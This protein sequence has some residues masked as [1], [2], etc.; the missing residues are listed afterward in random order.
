METFK[1]DNMFHW[2]HLKDF[3]DDFPDGIHVD[4]DDDIFYIKDGKIH[5]EDGPAVFER[6]IEEW[7]LD[8][9]CFSTFDQWLE[10]NDQISDED[11]TLLKLE[12]G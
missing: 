5:R 6:G 3:P 12:Y 11:R 1:H 10:M 2:R 8:G 7:W 4:I 9:Q